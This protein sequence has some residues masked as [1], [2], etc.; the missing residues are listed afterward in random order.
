MNQN[1]RMVTPKKNEEEKEKK[2]DDSQGREKTDKT[3]K[4]VM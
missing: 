1:R 4:R 3:D 2:A